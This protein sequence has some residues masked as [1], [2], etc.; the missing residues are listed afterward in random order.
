VEAAELFK[1]VDTLKQITM[2]ITT[3]TR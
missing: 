3:K 2:L 1:E